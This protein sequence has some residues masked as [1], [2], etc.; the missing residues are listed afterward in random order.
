MNITSMID[1][2]KAQVSYH[3]YASDKAQ[4]LNR[5]NSYDKQA[6]L[7]AKFAE[8]RNDLVQLNSIAEDVGVDTIFDL[9]EYFR[10][11]SSLDKNIKNTTSPDIT[12]DDIKDLTDE[13][14]D[15]L[16]LSESAKSEFQI[17][18]FI[19]ENGGVASVRK[20][21]IGI[22]RMTG[23]MP[24]KQTLNNRL[25]RMAHK[26]PPTLFSAPEFGQGYYS[27]IPTDSD[28][29]AEEEALPEDD[30]W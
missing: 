11:S 8:L 13:E 14:L 22:K 16:G 24:D 10:K 28:K 29:P 20:V 4:A 3:D 12:L 21:M 17:I 2:V 27:T 15:L 1:L 30:E 18:G 5:S 7:R 26:S 6:G 19:R 23:E 25:Y 9:I